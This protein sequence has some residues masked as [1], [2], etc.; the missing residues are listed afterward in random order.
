M[1]IETLAW[2]RDGTYHDQPAAGDQ[3]PALLFTTAG[4][5]TSDGQRFG[6][7][8]GLW[9]APGEPVQLHATAGSELLKVRFPAPA[10]HITLTPDERS[11]H[12]PQS[13]QA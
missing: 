7:H 1:A 12:A 5:F 3:R 6:A 10:S 2:T 11:L 8:A 4:E 13:I 9:A